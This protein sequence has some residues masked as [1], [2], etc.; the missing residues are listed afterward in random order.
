MKRNTVLVA[1]TANQGNS[2]ITSFVNVARGGT[3]GS[4]IAALTSVGKKERKILSGQMLQ[5]Q[6]SLFSGSRTSPT[7]TQAI[8]NPLPSCSLW[9]SL[10]LDEWWPRSK[11]PTWYEVS[12]CVIRFWKKLYNSAESLTKQ[13]QLPQGD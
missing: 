10:I 4:C 8:R 3:S 6:L 1:L 11:S 9:W 7:S 5:G 13:D 12:T 2:E